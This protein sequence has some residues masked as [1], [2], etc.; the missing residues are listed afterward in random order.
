MAFLIFMNY[1]LLSKAKW[2]ITQALT[3]FFGGRTL[4]PPIFKRFFTHFKHEVFGKPI[5]ISSYK[6]LSTP[7]SWES[8]KEIWLIKYLNPKKELYICTL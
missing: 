4:R 7:P 1:T 5:Y 2:R 8:D 6:P 3:V